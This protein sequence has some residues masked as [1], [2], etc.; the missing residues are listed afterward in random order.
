MMNT[1]SR[2]C[3]A[4]PR[5]VPSGVDQHGR[6][7]PMRTRPRGC[8]PRKRPTTKTNV[9]PFLPHVNKR[10]KRQHLASSKVAEAVVAPQRK[11]VPS[12]KQKARQ[13]LETTERQN[14]TLRR[15]LI[16]PSNTQ[17]FHESCRRLVALYAMDIECVYLWYEAMRRRS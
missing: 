1:P 7:K 16:D 15:G 5:H 8:S 3:A 17:A 2:S 4:P 14:E 12:W 9:N 10:S 6:K 11:H 13:W